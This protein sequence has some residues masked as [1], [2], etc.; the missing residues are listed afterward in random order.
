MPFNISNAGAYVAELAETQLAERG[1]DF[2]ADLVG[3]IEL[4]HAHFR[5]AEGGVLL[6]SHGDVGWRAP[7][8]GFRRLEVMIAL[9]RDDGNLEVVTS[10]LHGDGGW[11]FRYELRHVAG[12]CTPDDSPPL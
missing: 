4:D 3:D 1:N 8:T 12:R 6:W 2:S 7:G 9:A 11:F 10:L 5:R